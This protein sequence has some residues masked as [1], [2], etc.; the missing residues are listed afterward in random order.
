VLF[1]DENKLIELSTPNGNLFRI[2]DTDKGIH[3]EDENGNKATTNDKGITLEDKN[4]NGFVDSGETDPLNPSDDPNAIHLE[5]MEDNAASSNLGTIT[6]DGSTY[7]LPNDVT[8]PAGTYTIRYNPASGYV[9]DHWETTP[10]VSV[11][12]PNARSTT[13]TISGDGTL[14]AVYREEIITYIVH[15]E[16][17]EDNYDTSNLGKIAFD[18]TMYSLPNEITKS[19]G[20]YSINYNCASGYLFDHWETS[21]PLGVADPNAESTSVTVNGDGTLRA[22]YKLVI[23]ILSKLQVKAES[24]VNLL[25]TDPD[26]FRWIRPITLWPFPTEQISRTAEDFKIFLVV[27]MSCGQMVEDVKLAIAGKAPVLF[28]GRP[29]GGVPTVEAVLNQI[30]QLTIP[31]KR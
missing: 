5:S 18:G 29:G 20:T 22:I 2:S 10:G 25:V 28:Y 16:S 26:G 14:R 6:F 30:K 27:E 7:S 15:L 8:K 17:R 11:A 23:V 24:P 1:D 19:S 21:G 31:A 3:I 13:A 4:G 12:D 9:F